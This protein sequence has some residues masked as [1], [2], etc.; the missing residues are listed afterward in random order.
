MTL[1]GYMNGKFKIPIYMKYRSYYL[2]TCSGYELFGSK[3]IINQYL[4]DN[5]IKILKIN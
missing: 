3:T 1:I 5:N 2:L 4:K